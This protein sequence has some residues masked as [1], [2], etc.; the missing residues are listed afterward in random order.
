MDE[1]R[2]EVRELGGR[3]DGARQKFKT[4]WRMIKGGVSNKAAMR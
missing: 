4:L 3:G 1:L 2:V